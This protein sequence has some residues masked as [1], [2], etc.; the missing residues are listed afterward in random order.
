MDQMAII[1]FVCDKERTG[2]EGDEKDDRDKDEDD[3][4]DEK[5]RRREEEDETDSPKGKSL[6]F[7]S[8]K[9]EKLDKKTV[10]V[11]R[12]E[13]RTKYAC[14]DASGGLGESSG[15]WGFFTWF[16]IM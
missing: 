8:Y 14:E 12:L 7:N 15:R 1:E 6:K 3:T 16:I 10:G 13:W 4:E 5:F 11:L 2:L 9:E